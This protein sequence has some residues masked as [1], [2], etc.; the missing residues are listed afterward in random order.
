MKKIEFKTSKGEFVLVD[1]SEIQTAK[2]LLNVHSRSI[3]GNVKGMTEE[4]FSGIVDSELDS[5]LEQM[6]RDYVNIYDGWEDEFTYFFA[7]HSFQSLI[8]SLGFYLFTNPIR[9][10]ERKGALLDDG[11]FERMCKYEDEITFFNP[12]LL[13]NNEKN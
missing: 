12:I 4:Q 6:Y 7:R 1:L 9:Q 13:K 10:A 2:Y 5:H 8:N 11:R 3:I